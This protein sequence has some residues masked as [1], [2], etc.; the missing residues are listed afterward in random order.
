M[1]LSYTRTGSI[2]TLQITQWHHDLPSASTPVT[3]GRSA[4]TMVVLFIVLEDPL[5]CMFLMCFSTPGLNDHLI[6][7]PGHLAVYLHQ[8]R[9]S[10]EI[11]PVSCR[12]AYKLGSLPRTL[13]LAFIILSFCHE[14]AASIFT[15]TIA[16]QI[17][18]KAAQ[19]AESGLQF[20][21]QTQATQ[22]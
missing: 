6:I 9:W 1:L 4:C 3:S 22:R 12:T 5:P 2:L 7:E 21:R 13:L 19:A 16:V 17:F 20:R 11:F 10:S 14:S 8:V 15:D 18:D